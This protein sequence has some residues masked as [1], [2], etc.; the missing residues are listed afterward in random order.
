MHHDGKKSI[1]L[2]SQSSPTPGRFHYILKHFETMLFF[3]HKSM[4]GN[5]DLCPT[6]SSRAPSPSTCD[7]VSSVRHLRHM[8]DVFMFITY[9]LYFL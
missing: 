9:V 6:T 7:S 5:S 4:Q 1:V 8:L 2:L 3:V